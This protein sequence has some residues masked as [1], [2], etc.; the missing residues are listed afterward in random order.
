MPPL[1]RCL[2]SPLAAHRLDTAA[3]LRAS[4]LV[5]GANPITTPAIS[6]LLDPTLKALDTYCK[7]CLGCSHFEATDGEGE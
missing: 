2:H 1:V 5:N 6:S 7:P 3:P 4:Y